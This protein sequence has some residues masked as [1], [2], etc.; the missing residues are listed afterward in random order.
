MQMTSLKNKFVTWIIGY[1]KKQ[2]WNYFMFVFDLLV[3]NLIGLHACNFFK[4]TP[5][6]LFFSGIGETWGVV[7][8]ENM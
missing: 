2:T 8:S 5:T 1:R 6:Q 3:F 7:A 4:K